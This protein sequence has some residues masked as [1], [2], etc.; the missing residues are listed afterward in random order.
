MDPAYYTKI[1]DMNITDGQYTLKSFVT[2]DNAAKVQQAAT[3]L[4]KSDSIRI[5]PVERS[6]NNAFYNYLTGTDYE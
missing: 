3:K 6:V 5:N 1:V 4:I 2:E